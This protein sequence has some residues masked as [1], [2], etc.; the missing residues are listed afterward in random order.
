MTPSIDK[1]LCT[2]CSLCTTVCPIID[3][4]SF[5]SSDSKQPAYEIDQEMCIN[6]GRC[7]FACTYNAISL[8]P[9]LPVEG[10]TVM[11]KAEEWQG[12]KYKWG[13]KTKDGVDCSHFVHEVY[14]ELGMDYKY[15]TTKTFTQSPNFIE[16]PTP[17]IGDVI[18]LP[19]H[20][21]LYNPHPTKKDYVIYS[22]TSSKGIRYGK[23]S[24]WSGKATY[25]RYIKQ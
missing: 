9:S 10:M 5:D 25:Y 12:T 6:C 18:L 19:G 8:V 13:G 7:Y 22:A 1:N 3:C 15:Q 16:V 23:L 24:W 2:A 17:S 11:K 20:M 21:G 14:K 4:I